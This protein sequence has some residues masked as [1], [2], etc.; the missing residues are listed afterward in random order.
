MLSILYILI[1]INE[2]GV[3]DD[4]NSRNN[5]DF[6][7]DPLDVKNTTGVHWS[8][9]MRKV[10]PPSLFSQTESHNKHKRDNSLNSLTFMVFLFLGFLC[11]MGIT[12]VYRLFSSFFFG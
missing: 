7:R 4:F 12:W 1:A 8:D 5:L 11:L 6:Q 2:G 9:S 3:M 10:E